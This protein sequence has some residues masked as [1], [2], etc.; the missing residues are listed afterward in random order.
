MMKMFRNNFFWGVMLSF[1][2]VVWFVSVTSWKTTIKTTKPNNPEHEAWLHS[3]FLS[4]Q[5]SSWL[6]IATGNNNLDILSWLIIWNSHEIDGNPSLVIIGGWYK[7]KISKSNGGI[8]WW[9]KNTM[10]WK[11][12][13]IGWWNGNSVW[14]ENWSIGWWNGNSVWENWVVGWW[15]GNSANGSRAVILWGHGNKG[16]GDSLLLWSGAEWP[17]NSFVWNAK[18]SVPNSARIDAESWVLIWTI[19]ATTGVK[20]VISGAVKLWTGLNPQAWA[21]MLSRS[22]L[23][24][25]YDGSNYH[26]LGLYSGSSLWDN[27]CGC[28]FGWVK[29]EVWDIVKLYKK[30]YATNCE[31]QENV[32]VAECLPDWRNH[33][34][35]P[36]CYEISSDPRLHESWGEWGGWSNGWSNGWPLREQERNNLTFD[37]I[38][39]TWPSD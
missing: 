27:S 6:R 15:N 11:N 19:S 7:N 34:G 36:Y 16:W 28:R 8:G 20:L 5:D 22:W 35:Y 39:N 30:S 1:L 14:W 33:A 29:L 12:W 21:I 13:S 3:L 9:R 38:G 24:E 17:E 32:I 10:E 2:L 26:I 23:I 4:G 18:T 37:P 31:A 25:L